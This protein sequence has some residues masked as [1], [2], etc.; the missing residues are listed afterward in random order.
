MSPQDNTNSKEVK[1][2]CPICGKF[3]VFIPN[4]TMKINC[5]KCGIIEIYNQHLLTERLRRLNRI[6]YD[7]GKESKEP[8]DSAIW[9][10]CSACI[11]KMS[12]IEPKINKSDSKLQQNKERL[13][14][15][16]LM[17]S[18]AEVEI[19]ILH[20]TTQYRY[21]TIQKLQNNV[22]DVQLNILKMLD[23]INNKMY[24]RGFE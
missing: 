22:I 8:Y 5:L 4:S 11:I 12:V 21:N 20:Q 7:C 19:S 18:K 3:C 17:L 13:H 6:C 14:Q 24:K 2:R 1:N 9:P 23:T 15:I 10:K 16:Q